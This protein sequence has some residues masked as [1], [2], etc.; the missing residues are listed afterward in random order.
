ML[1][2]FFTCVYMYIYICTVHIYIYTYTYIYIYIYIYIHVYIYMIIDYIFT[3]PI[4][5][6]RYWDDRRIL[7]NSLDFI[8]ELWHADQMIKY[9]IFAG[10]NNPLPPTQKRMDLLHGNWTWHWN[11]AQLRFPIAM[12]AGGWC[13]EFA[14]SWWTKDTGVQI[15]QIC[16]FFWGRYQANIPI[17]LH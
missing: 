15:Y 14:T 11:T 1:L 9:N 16:Q 10:L 4:F 8:P 5:S 17:L 13:Q 12:V 6:W 2:V 3:K 7:S